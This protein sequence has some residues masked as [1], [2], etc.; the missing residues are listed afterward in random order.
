MFNWLFGKKKKATEAKK[1]IIPSRPLQKHATPAR[2]STP[3]ITLNSRPVVTNPRYTEEF[4]DHGEVIDAAVTLATEPAYQHHHISR[5][6]N[7]PEPASY[8][9]TMSS[10]TTP[11]TT[12]DTT[13]SYSVPESSSSYDSGSSDSSYSSSGGDF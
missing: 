6:L 10:D 13:A 3:P 2:T 1:V 7:D 9:E 8:G 4:V 11:D 12:P 5:L